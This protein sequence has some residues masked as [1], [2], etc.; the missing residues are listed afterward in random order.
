MNKFGPL[1]SLN[2]NSILPGINRNKKKKK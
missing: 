2:C 1:P